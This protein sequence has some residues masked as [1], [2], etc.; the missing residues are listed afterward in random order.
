MNYNSLNSISPIDGRYSHKTTDLNVFFSELNFNKYRIKV[1]LEYLR[2][3][4]IYKVIEPLSEDELCFLHLIYE[5]FDLQECIKLKQIECKTNHDVKSIEY[6]IRDKLDEFNPD[7]KISNYVHFGLTSQDINSTANML[8]IKNSLEKVIFVETCKV[9]DFLIDAFRK[10]EYVPMLAKTHGQT[11]S[12]Q[13][14]K[15]IHGFLRR[16]VIKLWDSHL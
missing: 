13:Q 8:M 2:Y 3:L 10:W 5:N 4:N 7:N 11:A 12:Q 15:R 14:W 9:S 16:L 1:E 6:Y